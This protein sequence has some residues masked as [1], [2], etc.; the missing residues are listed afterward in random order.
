M[1][2]YDKLM[3]IKGKRIYYLD[4]ESKEELPESLHEHADW[5]IHIGKHIPKNSNVPSKEIKKVEELITNLK[6]AI[7]SYSDLAPNNQARILNFKAKDML[8]EILSS[9]KMVQE[10]PLAPKRKLEN[11]Y[12]NFY[13]FNHKE[14]GK[15]T[16]GR[17]DKPTT[18]QIFMAVVVRHVKNEESKSVYKFIN[19]VT[20][21][22]KRL[23]LGQA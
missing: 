6:L 3:T 10:E 11:L 14:L 13:G 22:Y 23:I 4:D 7:M 12:N 19:Q 8:A 15:K 21:A 16:F 20:K 9:A 1:S 2:K 5:L 17:E 18:F